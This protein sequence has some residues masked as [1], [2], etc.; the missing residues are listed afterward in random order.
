MAGASGSDVDPGR[1]GLRTRLLALAGSGFVRLLAASVRFRFH[2]EEQVRAWERA[3]RPFIVAFWHRHL[4]LMRYAFRGATIHVLISRSSDGELIARIMH[5]LGVATVRGSSSR[6]GA[7]GVRGLLRAARRGSCLGI[8]PDGPRGP[9]RV[10]QPGVALV[11]AASQLPVV[12]V[13]ICARRARE[14]GSWD[15]MP[16]PWP[17]TRVEVVYGD[18]IEVPRRGDPAE[19]AGRIGEALNEVEREACRRARDQVR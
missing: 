15:R 12:P 3:G 16:V 2:G 10:A 11:A 14:L 6:G 1:G 9:L 13:A 18:A 5:R 17:W 19:W 7:A 8:T 4:L